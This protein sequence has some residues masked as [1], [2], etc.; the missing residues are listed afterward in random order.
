[1]N[2]YKYDEL[3]GEYTGMETAH[4]DPL[5]SKLKGK[6]VYLLP[7]NATY[8]P[9]LEEK[10]G[11][12]VIFKGNEWVYEEIPESEPLPEPTEE[13]I[14]QN[15]IW[16]LKGKLAETDYIVIKIAEGVATQ[17]EYADVL[18]KRKEW[19]AEINELEG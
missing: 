12:K 7:A 16:E 19:R 11:F 9:P 3:T 6:N 5:E 18:A 4:L 2:V 17:E 10:E 15:R 14:K 8:T 1:M 13:E